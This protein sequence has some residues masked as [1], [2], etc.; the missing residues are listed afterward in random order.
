MV[1][2][3][4]ATSLA[5]LQM[6]QKRAKIHHYLPQGLQKYFL[7]ENGQIW[8]SER[9]ND[10]KFS[11]PEPRNTS[12]TFKTRDYYTV[13]ED[14]KLSDRIEKDFYAVIDNFLSEFLNEIHASLDA[15]KVP[16]ISGDTL[17]SIQ[18]IAYHLIARTPS[19]SEKF[20]DYQIGRDIVEGTIT[21]ALEAKLSTREVNV[22]REELK[23][24]KH[25]RNLGRTVRVKAQ[26][27]PT[28]L[29]FDTLQEFD[30]RYSICK[31]RHSFILS[32]L[33]A[34]RIGNG[35]PNGL[36]NPNM[37]IW[38]PISPKRAL[39]LVRDPGKHI[40]LIVPENRNHI[41]EVNEFAVA[42]SNQIASHSVRLLNSLV[43]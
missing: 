26:A 33:G 20:D 9:Q 11:D 2:A 17:G 23:N 24:T 43:R 1:A 34:Y 36:S 37:E 25:L 35:G 7:D 32:G 30:V 16:L 28:K 42:R 29:I 8:Y 5:E 18:K 4:Y 10:G 41:R 40:P 31:G 3:Q 15:G 21:D 27:Q 22:L 12:S 6:S 14:G 19:F 39:V 38:L 13:Y